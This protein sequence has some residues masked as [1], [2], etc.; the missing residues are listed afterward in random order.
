M[1][2]IKTLKNKHT[3]EKRVRTQLKH[4]LAG[5]LVIHQAQK[6]H[7][8]N[9]VIFLSISFNKHHFVPDICNIF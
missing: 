6:I 7:W 5:I 9:R 4:E 8:T 2:M 1:R 3:K